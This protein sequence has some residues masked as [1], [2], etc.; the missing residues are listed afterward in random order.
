MH[1]FSNQRVTVNKLFKDVNG[2]KYSDTDCSRF[3][4]NIS[5][6]YGE[7][8]RR[9]VQQMLNYLQLKKEDVFYDL[10]SGVGKVVLQIAM[11]ASIRIFL[12]RPL[13]FCVLPVTQLI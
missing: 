12:M 11:A 13:C 10:G 9:G 8:T 6:I 2:W 1:K 3:C 5:S 7:L 4:S